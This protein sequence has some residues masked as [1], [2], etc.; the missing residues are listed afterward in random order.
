MICRGGIVS[1]S[2][3]ERS[4]SPWFRS[5]LAPSVT[6]L[7]ALQQRARPVHWPTALASVALVAILLTVLPHRAEIAPLIE[8][9]YAYLLMA[10]DRLHDGLGPTATPPVAPGQPWNWQGDWAFLTQWPIG[11]PVMI[12]SARTVFSAS[13]IAACRAISIIACAAA[14]VGWFLWTWRTV[15]PGLA[16][17]LLALAAAAS[18]VSVAS[19]ANPST[20]VLL[21]A[22]LPWILLCVIQAVTR[23]NHGDQPHADRGATAWLIVAGL[24]AGGLCWVRYGSIFIAPAIVAYL[25]Y[26]RFARRRLGLRHIVSFAIAAALPVLAIMSVNRAWGAGASAQAQMNLG[27][28]M[29]FDFSWTR[30]AQAWAMFTDLGYYDHRPEAPW[31]FATWPIAM[32]AGGLCFRSTRAALRTFF[33]RPAPCLSFVVLFALLALLVGS[34][35]VFGDKFD[36]VA[37]ERYYQPVRPLYLLLFATPLLLVPRRVVRFAVCVGLLMACS[38]TTEQEWSRTYHRWVGADRPTTS[39]Q[40]WSRCFEPG[41]EELYAWLIAQDDPSLIVVSNFHEYVALET[42]LPALP[43]PPDPATLDTWVEEIGAARGA[44]DL[45]VLFVLDPSNKRRDYWIAAPADVVEQFRLERS[46]HAPESIAPYVFDF[47]F[48]T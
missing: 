20:D 12:A 18:S 15:P 33:S 42:G 28:S 1:G 11:Y 27:Q 34:T 38:W 44:H 23:L 7:D 37:L 30:I 40:A 45:R 13:T 16:R 29:G 14:L 8:S 4:A 21:V 6:P 2:S 24:M 10:A 31:L 35:T 47:S 5:M 41:A 46:M 36:Y 43:I 39:Y 26:E 25:L 9:D 17:L 22:A 48:N 32:I 3:S 19:L